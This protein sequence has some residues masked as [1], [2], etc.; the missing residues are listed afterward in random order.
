MSR[1]VGLDEGARGG[2]ELKR[3]NGDIERDGESAKGPGMPSLRPASDLGRGGGTTEDFGRG[4]GD[5]RLRCEPG[6]GAEGG[7][8]PEAG[9]AEVEPG[10]RGARGIAGSSSNFDALLALLPPSAS[11]GGGSVASTRS[12]APHALHEIVTTRPRNLFS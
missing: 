3:G 8:D 12:G 11:G 5:E 6:A 1:R 9:E 4:G 7:P 2:S 10:K